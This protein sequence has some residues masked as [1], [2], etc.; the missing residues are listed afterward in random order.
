MEGLQ[1]SDM[2]LHIINIFILYFLL[3]SVLWK[4]VSRFLAERAARIEKELKDAEDTLG[5]AQKQKDL[6]DQHMR[7]FEEEGQAVLR[8]SRHQA[9]EKADEIVGDARTRAEQMIAD[10][11]VR[12]SSEK[13][14]AVDEVRSDAA[15]LAVEIASRILRREVSV[16]DNKAA[17]DEFFDDAR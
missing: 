5:E 8:E 13:K 15:L 10:A 7:T 12:I 3:R 17:A 11:R 9:I 2:L 1:I 6:Y 14:R 16:S 4:P